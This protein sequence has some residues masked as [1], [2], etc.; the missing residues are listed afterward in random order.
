MQEM[1]MH[2]NIYICMY[3]YRHV[4]TCSTNT[5]LVPYPM[6]RGVLARMHAFFG[7][8]GGAVKIRTM[9][10]LWESMDLYGSRWKLITFEYQKYIIFV[11]QTKYGFSIFSIN[12]HTSST[13]VKQPWH[14]IDKRHPNRETTSDMSSTVKQPWYV[15]NRE[16][17][18]GRRVIDQPHMP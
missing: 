15:L 17:M 10:R 12:S 6:H 3:L 7:G 8:G 16:T 4:C 13:T 1:S 9:W 14:V 2:R 18:F 11:A 5:S